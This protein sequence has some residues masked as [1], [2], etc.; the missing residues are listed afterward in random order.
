MVEEVFNAIHR[1]NQEVSNSSIPHTESLVKDLYATHGIDKLM[2]QHIINI[3]R[4]AHKI[5][6][7]EIVKEDPDRKMARVQGYVDA[8]LTTIHRLKA[9]YQEALIEMYEEETHSRQLYHQIKQQIFPRMNIISNTPLGHIANKAIMLEE[10]EK[11]LQAN[12]KEYTEDW[13]IHKLNEVVERE[14]RI[15]AESRHKAATETHTPE[16]EKEIKK[17]KRRAVDS[18]HYEDFKNTSKH[19][20]VEH[21]LKIFG[22]EFFLRVNLRKNNFNYISEMVENRTIDRKNDLVL[23]KD[24]VKKIKDN[25]KGDPTLA[26]YLDDLYSLDRTVAKF[27]H[28]SKNA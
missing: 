1:C 23:L 20:S 21:V 2:F 12:Y 19:E 13:K 7:I 22:V 16:Q 26:D 4:E 15:L 5:F 18:D 8:D 17:D 24:M 11:L 6:V 25:I 10:F 3:L 9:Y 14:D 28:F 27:I